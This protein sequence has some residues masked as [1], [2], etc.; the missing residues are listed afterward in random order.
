MTVKIQL[1]IKL[2]MP[3]NYI[4]R[5]KKLLYIRAVRQYEP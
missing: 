1:N 5:N 4:L 3:W 2:R